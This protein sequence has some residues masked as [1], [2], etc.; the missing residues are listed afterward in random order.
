MAANNKQIENRV[1]QLM[2]MGIAYPQAVAIANSEIPTMQTGG[3]IDPNYLQNLEAESYQLDKDYED[4][5]MQQ[6]LE[7]AQGMDAWNNNTMDEQL[8][9]EF[10][11]QEKRLDQQDGLNLNT[12][13]LKKLFNPYAGYSMED[14]LM[15][16]GRF[17]GGDRSVQNAMGFI[18]AP[19]AGARSFMS[20]QG[21]AK[22]E[23]YA[24]DEYDRRQ[25]EGL[26]GNYKQDGGR[27]SSEEI[28]NITGIRFS[29]E[30]ANNLFERR[31]QDSGEAIKR[32]IDLGGYKGRNFF[33]I[34][35]QGTNVRFVPTKENPQN[36]QGYKS[37]LKY[38]QKLNPNIKID[39]G[40]YLEFSQ[41]QPYR[42]Q[43]GGEVKTHTF[44]DIMRYAR[45]VE[46]IEETEEEILFRR[47]MEYLE[48]NKENL[49]IINRKTEDITPE[50]MQR[51]EEEK[52]IREH[53]Y[54]TGGQLTFPERMTGEYV[55][56]IPEDS[57]E[58]PVVELEDGEHTLQP[59]GV[60]SEVKGKKHS[61]G[62]EKL[63]SDQIEE[64][65]IVVSDHLKIGKDNA[66]YFKDK[67]NIK[68]KASDTYA[69]V[70]DKIKSKTGLTKLN[71]EQEKI[72]KEVQ[73]Q[74]KSTKD[75]ATKNIN[76]EFLSQ[77]INE[78]EEEKATVEEV[79]R[80]A[81]IDV[82]NVQESE[83]PEEEQEPVV[84][85]D[86]LNQVAQQYDI[87]EEQAMGI[88]QEYLKGGKI[89]KMQGGSRVGKN[90][91]NVKDIFER[92]EGE[93]DM[94]YVNRVVPEI[95]K[96]YRKSVEEGK[97]DP[98]INRQVRIMANAIIQGIGNA[99]TNKFVIDELTKRVA[100]GDKGHE[101]IFKDVLDYGRWEDDS[102]FDVRNKQ[103][104]DEGYP[105]GRTNPYYKGSDSLYWDDFN[106]ARHEIIS[107]MFIT[108]IDKRR[109]GDKGINVI[110]RV[111]EELVGPTIRK[112]VT[113]ND[114]TEEQKKIITD[115][116]IE[117]L[118]REYYGFPI[119]SNYTTDNDEWKETIEYFNNEL[120]KSNKKTGRALYIPRGDRDK[121][122]S[123]DNQEVDNQE[124][125]IE[126][127]E[128]T[129]QT[130]G[131]SGDK[132][133]ELRTVQP[134]LG[135]GLEEQYDNTYHKIW[136]ISELEAEGVSNQ[137][138]PLSEEDVKKIVKERNKKDKNKQEDQDFFAFPDQS[139]SPPNSM[140]APLKGE[141]RLG[142]A[143]AFRIDPSQALAKNQRNFDAQ[144]AQIGNL[145]PAQRAA[146][147]AALLAE[148]NSADNQIINSIAAQNAQ[149]ES[150]TDRFNLQRSDME[151]QLALQ[152]ALSYEDRM[153]RTQ[154][155]YDAN[156]D[157]YYDYMRNLNVAR[158]NDIR[159]QNMVNSIYEN[160]QINPDGTIG[161]KP[162]SERFFELNRML[163]KSEDK[164]KKDKNKTENPLKIKK[165]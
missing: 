97:K 131:T 24:Q 58:E 156:L 93:T 54:Q 2:A 15:G 146:A 81:L 118:N 95:E 31:V 17:V 27:V 29:E 71:K 122:E 26:V 7:W 130:T 120:K 152:N 5:Q 53:F 8:L 49:P 163:G 125:V 12:E 94:S 116:F 142:R 153:F 82:Y 21:L 104:G 161:V 89:P 141:V 92:R 133:E 35:D 119:F 87:P 68:V 150:E 14:A 162:D 145:P 67:Y 108:G 135:K 44:E 6:E 37:Q 90:R 115:D 112:I 41:R 151:E 110:N 140:V 66:K 57:L 154:A 124:E 46:G 52:M 143:D 105:E 84:D 147:Q 65:T 86:I 13:E 100:F 101:G 132:E 96:M 148:K 51:I 69:T 16:M 111:T 127:E 36:Y 10:R 123:I 4:L 144:M 56:G 42:M 107:E 73:K 34:Q 75:V 20:G 114:L 61:Q 109:D 85:T 149:I 102:A 62:G 77:K 18:K 136:S 40:A 79:V 121:V 9:K 74:E 72:I 159:N 48:N 128:D 106:K 55:Q 38:I 158:Y 76:L 22:T 63:T 83:K 88:V 126:R 19:L 113:N 25:R 91:K 117:F 45:A 78:L 70:V 64:G 30:A 98:E 103:I 164:K 28:E 43:E 80:E 139:V 23:K 47:F 157:A 129:T 134:V 33:N 165:S 99:N 60:M 39:N 59:D 138:K 50:E 160:Y 11:E 3:G 155:A 32:Q 137:T 1:K